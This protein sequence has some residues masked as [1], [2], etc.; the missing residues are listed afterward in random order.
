MIP[1]QRAQGS[2]QQAQA[3]VQ[4]SQLMEPQEQKWRVPEQIRQP[5]NL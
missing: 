1:A 4:E 5:S 3:L 2:Q